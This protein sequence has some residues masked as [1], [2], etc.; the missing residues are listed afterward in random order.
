M[1]MCKSGNLGTEFMLRELHVQRPW[2]RSMPG[3]VCAKAQGIVGLEL[4]QQGGV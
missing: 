3:G 4:R 2:G 1:N